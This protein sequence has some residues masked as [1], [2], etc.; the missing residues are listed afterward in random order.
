MVHFVDKKIYLQVKL[1]ADKK[2]KSKT[3]IYKSSWII[4]E[5]KKRNGKFIGKKPINT[6]LPRWFKE[7]WIDLNRPIKNSSGKIIGY[8][9]CGRKNTLTEKYPLCRPSKKITKKTPRTYHELTKKSINKAKKEKSKIK[10]TGNIK[11][12]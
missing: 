6:G 11:F 8:H 1:E 12:T 9:S 5:Y 4:R 7:N 3:S 2:F 10:Q